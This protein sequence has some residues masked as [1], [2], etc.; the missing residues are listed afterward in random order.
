MYRG[1]RIADRPVGSV[2]SSGTE[3]A[4]DASTAEA[5]QETSPVRTRVRH[6]S[7]GNYDDVSI[8]QETILNDSTDESLFGTFK[9][10]LTGQFSD[11]IIFEIKMSVPK[12][13]A[14]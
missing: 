5:S 12:S 8:M 11:K 6:N 9:K 3:A 1:L 4:A 14:A 2:P 13:Q 10:K 7:E